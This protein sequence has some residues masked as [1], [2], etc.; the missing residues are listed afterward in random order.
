[1]DALIAGLLAATLVT[2]LISGVIGMAG[3]MILMGIMSLLLP[4]E[5]A[6][7]LHGVT[8]LAANGSRAF[9]FRRHLRLGVLLP[10]FA[11]ATICLGLFFG[12]SYVPNEGVLCLVLGALPYLGLIKPKQ[13]ALDVTHRP[14]AFACG[15]SVTV[16]QLLAGVSGPLLDLFFLEARLDRHEVIGTKAITQSMGHAFKLAY[17]ARFALDAG[18]LAVPEWL[19]G[20]SV[21]CSFLGTYSGKFLVARMTDDAFRKWSQRVLLVLGAVYIWRGLELILT[22]GT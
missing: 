1:V 21:A 17:Y 22:A 13:L 10:Y 6:M 8:Q 3:G 2:S 14:T 9:L 11:G 16:A 20:A 19:F 4:V 5:T 18:E 12:V 7:L 15:F